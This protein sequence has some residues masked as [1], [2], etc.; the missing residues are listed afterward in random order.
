MPQIYTYSL[1]CNHADIVWHHLGVSKK[2]SDIFQATNVDLAKAI[3]VAAGMLTMRIQTEELKTIRDDALELTMVKISSGEQGTPFKPQWLPYPYIRRQF[4][5]PPLRN[6][7]DA[8][9]AQVCN[10]VQTLLSEL[11]GEFSA[12]TCSIMVGIWVPNP[13][14]YCFFM[15]T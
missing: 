11:E 5:S 2:A 12:K 3:D 8:F 6:K 1:I 14:S 9:W 13:K 10:A 15:E 7:K 4:F